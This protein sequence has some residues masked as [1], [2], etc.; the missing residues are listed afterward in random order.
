MVPKFYLAIAT[1]AR[2]ATTNAMMAMIETFF[3]IIASS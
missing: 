3:I 2:L 1:I